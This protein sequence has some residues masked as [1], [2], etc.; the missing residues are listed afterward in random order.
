MKFDTIIKNGTV[1]FP[2]REEKANIGIK[3]GKIAAVMACGEDCDGAYGEAAETVDARGL[4]VLP[5]V[6]DAHVHLCGPGRDGW[7]GFETGTKALAAGGTTC[8]V[9]MPLNNL[10][11]TTDGR[12]MAVKLAYTEGKSHVDYA[13]YGGLVPGNEDRLS[14]LSEAGVPAYKCFVASCG[15]GVEGDFVNVDDYT[16][17][18]GMKELARLGQTLSIHCEN[19]AVCD[20]LAERA[21]K[22]GR[23]DMRAYL[24]SR[25]V[26]AEVEAV[27]RVLYFGSVTGC[28]LHFVHL[29]SPEAVEAVLA[30]KQSGLS[31]TIETCPHYLCLTDED[32]IRIGADAKCSPPIRS[33]KTV[34]GMW[35]KIMA[36][37]IDV[38]ASDHSP[39]PA[40]MKAG[41]DM[42]TAWGGLSACQNLLDMMFD[43]A[44]KKRGLPSWKLM[45]MLSFRPAEIFGLPGKGSIAV[46]KDA[47]FVLFNPDCPYTVSEETLFYRH[48]HSAYLGQTVG[49]RVVRTYVRGQLAYDG[50]RAEFG[51]PF[52]KFL[53][54]NER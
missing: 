47:D 18:E 38:I 3:D 43:E 21:R 1:V 37:E 32:C 30:A 48:K 31:V 8:F 7:E 50:E 28:R 46:G 39:C 41:D 25:P 42:F 35:E 9:D 36:G 44:V 26:F 17:Y 15:F 45:Q 53:K 20:G 12:T 33:R 2:D 11:A 13:L 14:E 34:E 23:T 54:K 24:D 19:A 49:C 22:E 16:L 27:R 29:S 10:P 4:Y 5:G 40:D 52:G 6:V 51:E